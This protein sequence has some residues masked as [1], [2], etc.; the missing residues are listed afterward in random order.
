MKIAMRLDAIDQRKTILQE[1]QVENTRLLKKLVAKEPLQ[2]DVEDVLE[3]GPITSRSDLDDLMSRITEDKGL[4]NNL[5][6]LSLYF[7]WKS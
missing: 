4:K 2:C 7:I 3:S 6:K 5:V 1:M